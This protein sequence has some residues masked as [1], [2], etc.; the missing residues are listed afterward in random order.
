M[1]DM[2]TKFGAEVE[3]FRY[4]FVLPNHGQGWDDHALA[5][6]AAGKALAAIPAV[7]PPQSGAAPRRRA[8]DKQPTF[9]EVRPRAE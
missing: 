5:P 3:A 1:R 8:T 7:R 2:K 9:I 4:A 6:E